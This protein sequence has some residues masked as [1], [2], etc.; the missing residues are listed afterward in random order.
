MKNIFSLF[1]ALTNKTNTFKVYG[2]CNMCKKRIETAAAG[3]GIAKAE[4]DLKTNMMTVT[5]DP[6][7]VTI[8]NIQKRIAA[9]GHDTESETAPDEV[10]S[11]LPGCCL[12]ERPSGVTASAA[13]HHH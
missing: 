10:Y 3:E 2:S 13:I 9:A 12:Y 1:S 11:K 6:A 5:Y 8:T 7:K 4:W